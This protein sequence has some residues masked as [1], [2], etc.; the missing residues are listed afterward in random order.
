MRAEVACILLSAEPLVHRTV[1]GSEQM[2]AMHISHPQEPV[3]VL[4]PH[5]P[6][7]GAVREDKW[8]VHIVSH[9]A[10]SP[11]SRLPGIF[12][13]GVVVAN[14]SNGPVKRVNELHLPLREEAYLIVPVSSVPHSPHKHQVL[15]LPLLVLFPIVL[16][17]LQCQAHALES[18]RCP[19]SFPGYQH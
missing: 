6:D 17:P 12:F 5:L 19:L 7:E 18:L 15:I 8:L 1:P 16:Q 3:R 10:N 14:T 4:S 9:A 11:F 13:G 2:L